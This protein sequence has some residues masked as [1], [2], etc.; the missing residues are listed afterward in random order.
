MVWRAA[1][2]KELIVMTLRDKKTIFV[3]VGLL[4][5]FA[6]MVVV[7]QAV[8]TSRFPGANDFY[9]RWRGAQLFF[10]EGVDPYSREA[11]EAIQRG[12]YGRPA[13]PDEDQALFVYPFYTIFLLIPLIGMPYVWVQAVWLVTLQ[14]AL[15]AGVV[16][17]LRFLEWRL[18]TWLLALTLL[19]AVVFYSGTR[20]IILGQFAGLVFL[21]I[22]ATLLALKRGF[23]GLAA[24]LLALTTVKPQ[25]SFLFI[26][27]LLWWGIGQRRWRFAGGF[28]ASM[29][30]LTGVSFL[31][32]PRWPISFIEQVLYYPGYTEFGSPI[33]IL[34]THYFPQLG[35][36][37]EI[38]LSILVML[39]LFYEWRSLPE[40]AV[41]SPKFLFVMALTLVVTN[42]V[43]TRT[44][45]T[46]YVMLYF[47]LLWALRTAADSRRQGVY[48]VAL[49]YFLS[50]AGMWA[51]FL[52]TLRG[53]AENPVMFL[54]LPI[55]L[56]IVLVWGRSFLQRKTRPMASQA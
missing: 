52:G 48:F 38:V 28:V 1:V 33:S 53:N 54:P 39:Y 51:L 25:M 10:L 47:P 32:S 20:T 46:N 22:V 23:D 18:P 8:F 49:F 35:Q 34:T 24:V 12:L 7:T 6:L 19:W 41:D 17:S 42:L 56:F 4:W 50:G 45:T 13:L 31:L 55:G 29:I 2:V 40:A 21:W 5:L 3:V 36:P 30:V 37:V 26:P 15:I 14:F 16:L 11:T 43:A 9:P 27:A 44:G